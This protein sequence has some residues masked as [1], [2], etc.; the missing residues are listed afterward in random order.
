[1]KNLFDKYSI[2]DV[3][4]SQKAKLNQTIGK[5][6]SS[7][8]LNKSEGDLFE[9]VYGDF[10]MELPI[11]NEEEVY[12]T[13]EETRVDVSRDPMR[14]ISNRNRPFYM[15]GTRTTVKIP[16]GGDASYFDIAPSAY[17]TTKPFA[18]IEQNEIRLIFEQVEANGEA[19]KISYQRTLGEIRTYL[20]WLQD[21]ANQYNTEITQIIKQQI[22]QRKSQIV[23]NSNNLDETLGIPI[24]TVASASNT[25]SVPIKRKRLEILNTST[26]L[27]TSS[28]LEPILADNEYSFILE[29]LKNMCFA[30]EKNPN[31]YETIG[32][33]DLRWQ[34]LVQLNGQYEGSATGETF[35][36]KGKTDI[37]IT[38]K[39]KNVFIGECKFWRGE[40]VFLETID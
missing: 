17:T 3:M 30:M 28:P 25:Y 39:G 31:A 38:E 9:V 40:S 1:M 29:T 10:K 16:F 18:E 4:Y 13:K 11:I 12:A 32:E 8:L 7:T 21:N 37:L 2:F 14:F 20:N 34:F 33:E 24:K 5:I 19:I 15:N 6:D 23:A 27:K 22:S 26:M 35:N 36:N